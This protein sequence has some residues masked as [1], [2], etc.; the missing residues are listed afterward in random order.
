METGLRLKSLIK[1]TGRAGDET[2]DPS[3]QEETQDPLVQ[4]EWFIHYTMVT[5]S[6][7]HMKTSKVIFPPKP[8]EM[9]SAAAVRDKMVS[10]H[11]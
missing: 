8:R 2:Q 3:V 9:S 6:K 11:E 5:P 4:G 10:A 7:I 1:Q